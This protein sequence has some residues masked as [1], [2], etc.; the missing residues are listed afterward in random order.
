MG[1]LVM[2]FRLIILFDLC[3]SVIPLL[4]F[5]ELFPGNVMTQCNRSACLMML[6][7]YQGALVAAKY[8]VMMEPTF[9]TV[10]KR[11]VLSHVV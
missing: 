1:G 11:L 6:G 8:T 7:D 3:V 9:V 5:A 4:D 2:L 10:R